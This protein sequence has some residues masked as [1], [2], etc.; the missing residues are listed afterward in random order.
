MTNDQQ[1]SV[2][3]VDDE[4]H[5]RRYVRELVESDPRFLVLC[6]YPDGASAIA[7]IQA[8]APNVLFLDIEMP[9]LGGIEV[10]Q[11]I[12]PGAPIVVIVSA[13]SDY[14]IQAFEYQVLDYIAKPIDPQRFKSSLNR[15]YHRFQEWQLVD[16]ASRPV[17]AQKASPEVAQPSAMALDSVQGTIR[18]YPQDVLFLESA[19]NYVKVQLLDQGYLVRETLTSLVARF[20]QS[21]FL[22]VHR[23]FAVNLQH[24][25]QMTTT[26]QGK[27]EIILFSGDSIPV[28]R[29]RLRQVKSQLR[30]QASDGN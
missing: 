19:G 15:V 27:A 3:I 23:C 28:S 5:G 9:G 2:T 17:H 22:R 10:L 11:A 12:T 6:E 4:A 14:A 16:Q 26:A 20:G 30:D 21:E 18:F 25:R 29:H 1:V 8:A 13:F 24:V 7:G